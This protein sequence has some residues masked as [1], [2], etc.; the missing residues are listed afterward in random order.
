VNEGI[1]TNDPALIIRAAEQSGT[2]VKA[3]KDMIPLIPKEFM[4]MGGPTH[5]L[6][7]IMADSA[8]TN[9]NPEVARKQFTMQIN[10]CISCHRAYRMDILAQ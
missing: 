8:R 7:D 1:N 10:N 2:S 5:K 6:F 9:F 3:P 4:K